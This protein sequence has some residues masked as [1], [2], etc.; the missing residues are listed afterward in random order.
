MGVVANS[1]V[2][3]NSFKTS[4]LAKW[5]RLLKVKK[6]N[7]ICQKRKNLLREAILN[8]ALA[9][10]QAELHHKQQARKQR[11]HDL[12][13]SCSFDTCDKSNINLELK[14]SEELNRSIDEFMSQLK[15]IKVPISR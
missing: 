5:I 1:N 9:E 7:F 6:N 2:T 15:L 11:W 10:A 13:S 8:K 14:F 12:Q 4:E 3:C